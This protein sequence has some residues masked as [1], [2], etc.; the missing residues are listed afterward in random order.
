MSFG[1]L[2]PRAKVVGNVKSLVA[3]KW[4]KESRKR[5]HSGSVI[6]HVG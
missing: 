3:S 2:L 6:A 5:R 4:V 1:R